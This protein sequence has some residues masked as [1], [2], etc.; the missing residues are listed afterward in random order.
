MIIFVNIE[1]FNLI[2]LFKNLFYFI[3]TYLILFKNKIN[4]LFFKSLYD[5]IF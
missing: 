5:V 3:F 4:R 1:K 2:I